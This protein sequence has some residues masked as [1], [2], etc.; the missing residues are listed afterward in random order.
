[1]SVGEKG[2]ELVDLSTQILVD[3]AFFLMPLRIGRLRDDRLLRLPPALALDGVE[4]L[5]LL[6]LVPDLFF[7]KEDLG[8]GKEREVERSIGHLGFHL[9]DLSKQAHGA[10]SPVSSPF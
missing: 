3:L 10:D 5:K 8:L 7:L 6:L 9:G 1:M 2:P 4:D